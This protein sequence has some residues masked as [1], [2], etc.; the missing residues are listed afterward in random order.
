MHWMWILMRLKGFK[1]AIIPWNHLSVK[2][3]LHQNYLHNLYVFD[4]KLFKCFSIK[5]QSNII[6]QRSWKICFT[7]SRFGWNQ[8]LTIHSSCWWWWRCCWNILKLSS[9]SVRYFMWTRQKVTTTDAIQK[10]NQVFLL[11][12]IPIIFALNVKKRS[13]FMTV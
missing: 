10:V 8:S 5:W 7:L 2:T 6:D 1:V 3:C 9:Y 13:S 4:E 11:L 12:P